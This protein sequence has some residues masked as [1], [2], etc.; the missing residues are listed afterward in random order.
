MHLP[1]SINKIYS[2]LL[3]HRCGAIN[4]KIFEVD[5]ASLRLTSEERLKK[6]GIDFD[7]VLFY[8]TFEDEIETSGYGE[9]EDIQGLVENYVKDEKIHS[10]IS[11]IKDPKI[12]GYELED[13]D[14]RELS[15]LYKYLTLLHEL[16]HVDDFNNGFNYYHESHKVN[17]TK[18]EAYADIFVIKYLKNK[19]NPFEKLALKFFCKSILERKRRDYFYSEVH[20]EITKKILESKIRKWALTK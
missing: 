1:E 14:Y 18:A 17:L 10:V 2:D 15:S 5:A 6:Y 12:D 8:E 4:A 13:S 11:I 9:S 3:N 19:T 7:S 20:K 16:G